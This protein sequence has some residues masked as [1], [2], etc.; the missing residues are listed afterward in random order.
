MYRRT[1][2][3]AGNCTVV[4]L[5]NDRGAFVDVVPQLGAM[6]HRIGLISSGEVVRELLRSD[7]PE[8]L[9]NNP[10]YRGRLLF[11]FND[12]I[13]QG[14]YT[15]EG[16]SYQLPVNA[17]SDGSSIHGLVYN[18]G[19]KE[20]S[21]CL[22]EGL[23]KISFSYQIEEGEWASYPFSAAV[24]VTYGL[25][26]KGFTAEYRISNKGKKKMPVALGWHPYFRLDGLVDNWTLHC[27]G[28]QYVEVDET[29]NPT[30]RIP[31]VS[32]TPF[33]FTSPRKIEGEELDIALTNP[34]SGMTFLSGNGEEI[35]LYFDPDFFPYVQL[36]TPPARDSLAIEPITAAT[37]AF[38]ID[39]LG[40]LDLE[41]GAEKRGTVVIGLNPC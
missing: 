7:L 10:K 21:C 41:P 35:S 3:T 34:P 40:R 18:R 13:P 4:R 31:D 16:V 20:E 33:D 12:R 26:D 14:K 2:Y 24:V 29:L 8:E 22:E 11:P 32:G 28:G 5:E 9:E 27:E 38:N 19:F 25:S 23:A 17:K 6:V 36:Y 30:G 39:Q 1:E 37:N 15:Y